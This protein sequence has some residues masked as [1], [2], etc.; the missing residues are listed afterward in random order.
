MRAWRDDLHLLMGCSPDFSRRSVG[1]VGASDG[2]QD[3][4]NFKMDCEFPEA[5]DGN[6]AL[7]AELDLT[8]GGECTLAVAF[9]RTE[10]SATTKLLQSLAA[11]FAQIGRLSSSNG[12]ARVR[13]S[14]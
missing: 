5:R 8:Q 9:G 11:P 10:Q 6:L 3:L 2:W 14:I 4:Q 7:S 12:V 1:Y 13:R